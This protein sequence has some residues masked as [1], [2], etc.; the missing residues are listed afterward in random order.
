MTGAAMVT[1]ATSGI[2]RALALELARR[3]F[4]LL[5]VARDGDRL[6]AVAAGAEA[7]GS[8]EVAIQP[9]D[10]TDKNGLH[11]VSER[12]ADIDFLVNAAGCG[13]TR[14]F[15]DEDLAAELAMLDLNVRSVLV[16]SHAA[17][18]SMAERGH[19]RI[20]NVG[21]TAAVW[22]QGTYAGGKAWVHTTTAGMVSACADRGVTVTL[23][24]PGFTRTEFHQRSATATS[25][26]RRWLWLAPEQ[27]AREGVDAMLAGQTKCI[28]SRRYRVLVRIATSLSPGN[29]RRLLSHLASLKPVD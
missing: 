24:V 29:R 13:T 2:G 23:L 1:G 17:A 18:R 14:T 26:V 6:R 27:V 4:P 19:G 20:L 25:G 21:S 5:L 10:L 22:S 16:L 15:P 3:G 9:A 12:I 28:P 8:P 7:A 11:V